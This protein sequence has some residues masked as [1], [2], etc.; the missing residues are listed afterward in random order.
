MSSKRGRHYPPPEIRLW[1][2]VEKTETCWLWKGHT[3]SGY[4]MFSIA[5]K[6][7]YIHRYAYE[8]LV[9]PIPEGMQLDHLCRV[10][11]CVNPDHLE[12]V[13]NRE[14]VLR[15]LAATER[16]THCKRGH[17]LSG[18]NLYLSPTGIRVC[19]E[20]GK[21]RSKTPERRAAHAAYQLEWIKRKKNLS[22]A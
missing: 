11:H 18:P 8:L 1:A 5:G 15:G 2:R 19:R 22:Q 13:T 12:P 21:L 6:S 10:R 20:C 3:V 9:G 7:I 17:P 16:K 4:G 14:N